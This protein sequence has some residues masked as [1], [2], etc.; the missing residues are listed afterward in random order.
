MFLLIYLF[1]ERYEPV[2][3]LPHG[4]NVSTSLAI[5]FRR[6]GASGF[7]FVHGFGGAVKNA[8]NVFGV[9]PSVGRSVGVVD[10][11]KFSASIT[12]AK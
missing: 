4:P 8:R 11:R 10:Q 5:S 9:E 3:V 2:A 6:D 7:H 1:A 12:F